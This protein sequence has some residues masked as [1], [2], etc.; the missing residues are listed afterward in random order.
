[1]EQN[2]WNAFACDVSEHLLLST[3]ER[4]V[5]LGLRDLG[6]DHVVLDDCWQDENGRDA[7]GKLQPNPEK[8]PNGLNHVSD[9]IHGLGLK[10]GMYSTA[11]EMTCARFGAFAAA[12]VGG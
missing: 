4:I 7:Q 11:G 5:S 3:S 2:N 9:H 6:Y 10:Y 1:M 8:F 12:S